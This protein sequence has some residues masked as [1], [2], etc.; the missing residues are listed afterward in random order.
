M[1]NQLTLLLHTNVFPN[2]VVLCHLT[3]LL[4]I[5]FYIYTLSTSSALFQYLLFLFF[6]TMNDLHEFINLCFQ[7]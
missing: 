1:C 4:A 7:F 6:F 3:H 5:I 2:H